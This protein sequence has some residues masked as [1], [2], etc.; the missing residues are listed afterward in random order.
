MSSIKKGDSLI[1]TTDSLGLTK[2]RKCTYIKTLKGLIVVTFGKN[3]SGQ[4][5]TRKLPPWLVAPCE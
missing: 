2:G 5:L 1:I 3:L 4:E